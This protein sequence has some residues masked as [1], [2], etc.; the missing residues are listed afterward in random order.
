MPFPVIDRQRYFQY[1]FGISSLLVINLSYQ[2]SFSIHTTI[3]YL[4]KTL[5]IEHSETSSHSLLPH[6]SV[7]P[8]ESINNKF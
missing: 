5:D 4:H 3:T 1:A 6:Y 8:M 7:Q 2:C